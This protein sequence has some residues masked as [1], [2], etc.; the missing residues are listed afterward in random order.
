MSD[1]AVEARNPAIL[2]VSGDRD[3]K[4][5]LSAEISK[6]YG[7]DYAIS[8]HADGDD[9]VRRVEALKIQRTPIAAVLST[10]GSSDR[11]G[12]VVLDR[13]RELD[14]TVKRAVV[15]RWADFP[16]WR[17]AAEAQTVGRIDQ[18][19]LH[20]TGSR[21]EEFHSSMT[22]LL[23]DW[24]S[25][26]DQGFEA[27]TIIGDPVSPRSV[28]VRDLLAR[29]D[30]PYRFQDAASSEGQRLLREQGLDAP[31]LPVAIPH[32]RPDAPVLEDPT[33]QEFV[34]TLRPVEALA[35]G[36]CFDVTIVGAGPGGLTTAVYA[37]SEGL[38]TVVIEREAIG[39]QAGTTSMIRN[40]P[41][42]P[43]GVTGKRLAHRAYDQ[44][45]AFGTA[46]VF[47]REATSLSFDDALHTVGLSDG[48]TLRSRVVVVATGARYRRLGIDSIDEF[49]G[50]G[51]FYTPVA[52]EVPGMIG[53]RVLIV[54]GGNSA[55]Q[56]AV[57]VSKYAASVTLLVRGETLAAS[58][59]EYLRREIEALP[60]VAV[61]FETALVHGN[62]TDQLNGVTVKNS[63]S[64]REVLLNTDALFV[65]IGSSPH[66]E[67]LHDTVARDDWG[68]ILTGPDAAA[69]ARSHPPMLFQSSLPSVFAVGDVRHGSVKRVASAVGEGA[70][71]V[72]QIHAHLAASSTNM[73]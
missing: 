57:H 66:T 48:Q 59:S 49:I 26:P 12:L 54:G 36:A 40:Y 11:V 69:E 30:V 7:V 43:Q 32:F 25:A 4:E 2:V 22:E 46:F 68:F 24:S 44:A 52:S 45:L 34:D 6:R 64:G 42:F 28:D 53:K 16:A 33:D 1:T 5:T 37:A 63:R 27:V 50:R 70:I 47:M 56:A 72:Q 62:G 15:V 61:L 55:G 9:A 73:S 71:A 51:V 3:A 23:E 41:G 19:L 31:A 8:A 67:W 38:S 58:M 17:A 39:G 14:P 35:P 29:N 13:L 21:D 10:F 60:N 20:P 18:C 65:L